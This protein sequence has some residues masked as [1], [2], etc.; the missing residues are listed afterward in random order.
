MRL[1]FVRHA[2]PDYENDSL[3]EKGFREA[4]ILKERLKR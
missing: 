3:T 4:E 1:V 2:E